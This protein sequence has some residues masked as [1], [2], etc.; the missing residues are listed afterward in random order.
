MAARLFV[1]ETRE[2]KTF[3]WDL[4]P[5][6]SL[7]NLLI[8]RASPPLHQSSLACPSKFNKWVFRSLGLPKLLFF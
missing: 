6:L 1:F 5:K 4:K 2:E 3:T 8:K 7:I